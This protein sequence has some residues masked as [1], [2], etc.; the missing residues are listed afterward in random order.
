MASFSIGLL[1]IS[2]FSMQF[3]LV[4]DAVS[5]TDSLSV[6]QVITS[7]ETLVSSGKFFVRL[8]S[9][10]AVEKL[11]CRNMVQEYSRKDCSMGC[12]SRSTIN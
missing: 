11:L 3:S 6:G 7:S 10:R 12:Q 9:A 4:V 5:D 1:I 8:F 2:A